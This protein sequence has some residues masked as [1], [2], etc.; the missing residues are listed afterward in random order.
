MSILLGAIRG[1]A[2]SRC[3]S[4]EQADRRLAA[5]L[6]M[7]DALADAMIQAVP[8]NA[9]D[10]QWRYAGYA[11][12]MRKYDELARAVL[13]VEPVDA[14][15]D[16]YNLEHLPSFANTIPM[17]QR[18]YFEEVRANLAILRSYL[19]NRVHPKGERI[20]GLAD[21]L[22]A[23]LRRATLHTP[24][25]ETDVQDVVEQLLIGKGLEKGLD[26]DRESGR[27]KFS[28]KEVIPDFNL[29]Q[30]STSIEV[31]LLKSGSKVGP[32]IDQINADV[33]ASVRSTPF[34]CTSSTTAVESSQTYP[35]SGVTLRPLT[36]SAFSSSNTSAPELSPFAASNGAVAVRYEARFPRAAS[37]ADLSCAYTSLW[38]ARSW[39]SLATWSNAPM[40]C[41]TCESKFS[42][43]LSPVRM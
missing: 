29:I 22:E 13:A 16:T 6:G 34:R 33:L 5:Y 17:Q 2:S 37:R 31:K 35:S 39:G 25:R 14:P 8:N 32:A 40:S 12:Y 28:A 1:Q 30:L 10:D 3:V 27:V 18:T 4:R 23:N 24:E 26:Y 20:A 38:R 21:F 43:R 36:E 11:Q 19:R 15:I 7:A 42:S 9:S 41:R